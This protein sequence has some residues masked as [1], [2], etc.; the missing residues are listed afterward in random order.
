MCRLHVALSN[1]N[2]QLVNDI[3]WRNLAVAWY[4]AQSVVLF[5]NHVQR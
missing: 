1:T 2:K 4:E 3:S 5:N